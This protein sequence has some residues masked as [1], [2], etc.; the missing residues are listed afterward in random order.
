MHQRDEFYEDRDRSSSYFRDRHDERGRGGRPYDARH[1]HGEDDGDWSSRGGR[2]RHDADEDHPTG[3]YARDGYGG[4]DQ[5]R[6]QGHSA[7]YRDGDR[8]EDGGRSGFGRGQPGSSGF[9]STSGGRGGSSTMSG[10]DDDTGFDHDYLAWRKRTL[11]QY[12]QDYRE[13]LSERQKSFGNE[14]EDWRKKRRDKDT[15]KSAGSQSSAQSSGQSGQAA[16]QGGKSE[17]SSGSKKS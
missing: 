15:G 16:G 11:D 17:D 8:R 13:F 4:R 9:G 10:R 12:D 2:S 1:D 7:R 3:S 14:F 5:E 6:M